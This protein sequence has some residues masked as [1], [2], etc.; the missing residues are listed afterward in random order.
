MV[1][2]RVALVKT[3]R[4]M[5]MKIVAQAREPVASRMTWAK[6][7]LSYQS[8]LIWKPC[9]SIRSYDCFNNLPTPTTISLHGPL[10]I[11]DML[12]SS[13]RAEGPERHT[14]DPSPAPFPHPEYK[15]TP[16]PT[17]STPTRR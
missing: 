8:V 6:G 12:T 17:Q 9:P 5:R 10:G 13:D 1:L 4:M 11:K 7:R 16:T 14:Q 2:P 15:T 3:T